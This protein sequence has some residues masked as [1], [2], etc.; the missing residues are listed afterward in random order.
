MGAA[1]GVIRAS[2]DK[3]INAMVSLAGMVDTKAFAQ[4]E[5]GEEILDEGLMWEESDC[6]LSSAF[7][8]D[9]CY[10]I[11]S[12]EPLVETIEAPWLLIHGS[13][14]DVV[15]P[16]DTECVKRIKGGGVDTVFIEG[17]D[18][19]FNDLDHK[20]ALVEAVVSWLSNHS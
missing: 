9:L 7:M 11:G 13:V 1:V 4:T 10:T 19:S 14:D 6:P 18:H 2:A 16:G 3:R 20:Q 12:V 5:F 17:A 15:D 8:K